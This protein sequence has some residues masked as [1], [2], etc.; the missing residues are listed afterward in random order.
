MVM[1]QAINDED[2]VNWK[3]VCEALLNTLGNDDF[4]HILMMDE[5]NFHLCGNVN[6]Q[7]C[8]YWA[9][10]D[11]RVIHQT[12]LHSEKVMVWCGVASFGV[13]G[14][15][16]FEDE[17]GRAVTVNSACYTETLCTFLEPELQRLGVETQT[18]WFQQDGTMAHTVRTAMRVL[19]Q[20]FPARVISRRGNIEWPARSPNLNTC[21][22]FLW[23]YLKSKVYEK[24]PRTTEDLKQNIRYEVAAI[25]PTMLQRVMQNF[26]K[27]LRE[28]VDNNGRHLTDTIFKK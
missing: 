27:C 14:P 18:L 17:A 19:N 8:R 5:A 25:S 7:N 22:F 4:N 11:P 23:G 26:Q 2:T 24:K 16:F 28:C 10:E 9:T 15:Y 3:T 20:M 13:I 21:D 6:S 12:P 1:V